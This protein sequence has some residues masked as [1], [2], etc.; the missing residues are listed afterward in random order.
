M[1]DAMVQGNGQSGR[2]R[3]DLRHAPNCLVLD[4]AHRFLDPDHGERSAAAVA[5][6][7]NAASPDHIT[8]EQVYPVVRESIRRGQVQ[9]RPPY[10]ERLATN[11]LG[12]FLGPEDK[13]CQVHV[14]DAAGDELLTAAASELVL[15]LG[16]GL[17]QVPLRIGLGPGKLVLAT[18]R[19]LRRWLRGERRPPDFIVCPLAPPGHADSFPD[20]SPVSFARCFE[21]GRNCVELATARQCG[22]VDMAVGELIEA[23][24]HASQPAPLPFQTP[25]LRSLITPTTQMVVATRWPASPDAV[26]PLLELPGCLHLLV[27][28][29][30]AEKWLQPPAQPSSPSA[31]GARRRGCIRT[32]RGQAF[33]HRQGHE[34][35]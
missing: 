19:H 32:S 20:T 33:D 1:G 34:S 14:V 4:V 7:H 35:L 29:P 23:A 17:G 26:T 13:D 12:T 30:T 11:V 5:R 6:Q 16:A 2:S 28:V 27:D 31:P 9:F 22:H 3:R 25:Q 21:V 10:D 18:V 24:S 15:R 8:R